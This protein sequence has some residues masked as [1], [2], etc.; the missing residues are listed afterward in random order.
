MR[1]WAPGLI[2]ALLVCAPAGA[3]LKAWV[4]EHGHTHVTDDPAA[5]PEAMRGRVADEGGPFSL[6][7]RALPDM[8]RIVW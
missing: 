7:P 2:V 1:R 3:D 6:R 5:V 8:T 4:D